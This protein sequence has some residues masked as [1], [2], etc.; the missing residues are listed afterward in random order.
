[1]IDSSKTRSFMPR[2]AAIRHVQLMP[3]TPEIKPG[4]VIANWRHGPG[5]RRGWSRLVT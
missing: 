3:L 2:C 4:D 5:R 1:M